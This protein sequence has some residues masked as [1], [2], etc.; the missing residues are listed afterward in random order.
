MFLNY[1]SKTYTKIGNIYQLMWAP[2][3]P[4]GVYTQGIIAYACGFNILHEIFFVFLP[5]F[6]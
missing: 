6:V 2:G 4:Y 1:F 5:F 3:H